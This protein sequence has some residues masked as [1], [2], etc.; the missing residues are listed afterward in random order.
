MTVYVLY[1][2]EYDGS[3]VVGVYSSYEK[4]QSAIDDDDMANYEGQWEG[5][6]IAECVL[7]EQGDNNVK[8][9]S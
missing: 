5:Y 7:D 2:Q 9:I 3:N 8:R 4:A 1:C 6:H